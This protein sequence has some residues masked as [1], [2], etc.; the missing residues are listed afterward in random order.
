MKDQEIKQP[1]RSLRARAPQEWQE[2]V[3]MFAEYTAEA[4]DAVTDADAGFIMTAKG[5]AQANKAWLKT[6]NELDKQPSNQG[7]PTPGYAVA[8][9]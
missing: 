8:G 3:T 6:F 9:P 2:F 1:C 4:V 5:F 7:S